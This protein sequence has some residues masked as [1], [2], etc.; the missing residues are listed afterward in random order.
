LPKIIDRLRP[1][2]PRAKIT[3]WVVGGL[4]AVIL[5]G[6]LG[7]YLTAAALVNGQRISMAQLSKST[8]N[9]Y[10]A[11]VLDELITN[12]LVDQEI[13]KQGITVAAADIDAEI[14]SLKDQYAGGDQATW[15]S[16]LAQE[17]VTEAELRETVR[18]RM[19]VEQII[20][21][22]ITVTDEELQTYYDA[23]KDYYTEPEQVRAS[24]IVVATLE[25]AQ[26]IV[27]Q[28]KG[29]ADFA[30]L[31]KEKSISEYSKENGGDLGYFASA[32]QPADLSKAAFALPVGQIS[33]PI[34]IDEQ[35][36][37]IKV[38]DHK[39]TKVNALADIRDQ[40]R[41]DMIASQVEQKIPEWLTNIKAKAK[42]VQRWKS[43]Q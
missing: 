28:L 10:G 30:A 32:D 5:V 2:G 12:K 37:V 7:Y 39:A 26:A 40:V 42:I 35:Y 4:I 14:A 15:E 18:R 17:G 41:K 25:E 27:T 9:R 20:G 11:D 34:K 1:R 19:G 29:G 13:R 33:D 38:I 16:V 22:D 31:A 21:K 8:L 3:L 23:N 43:G 24:E 6:A 36:Y